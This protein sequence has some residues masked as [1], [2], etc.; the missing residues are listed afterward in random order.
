MNIIIRI[1]VMIISGVAIIFIANKLYEPINEF[2]TLDTVEKTL[3]TFFYIFIANWFIIA[4]SII[5][6]N[7]FVYIIQK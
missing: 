5:F 6:F 1:I 7:C 2:K 4:P 3:W